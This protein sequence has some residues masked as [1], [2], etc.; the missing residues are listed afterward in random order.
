MIWKK[1]RDVCIDGIAVTSHADEVLNDSNIDIVVE[2]MGGI[3]EAKQHIVKALRNKKH[4]VTANKDLMAV[5]GAE[6][7]QLANDNDCDL[8]YEASVAGGI[9][10]L[11]GL[12][13]GLASDQ[14]EKNN[15]NCKWY[16]K[17]YV[18]KK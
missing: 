18:N 4:V 8:C 12:T 11:R 6:L 5:Y 3:E 7:L 14:I 9:P 10:V 2:V 17:L 1:E 16:N 15:G 13:D